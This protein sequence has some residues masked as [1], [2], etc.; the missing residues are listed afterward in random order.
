MFFARNFNAVIYGA[1][2][3]GEMGARRI[4]ISL[5]RHWFEMATVVGVDICLPSWTFIF[6]INSVPVDVSAWRKARK[7]RRGIV[8]LKNYCPFLGQ[9]A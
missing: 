9:G 8:V 4:N 6:C 7:K 5:S 2:A 3:L 1:V